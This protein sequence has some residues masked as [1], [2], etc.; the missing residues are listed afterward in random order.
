MGVPAKIEE[1][2]PGSPEAVESAVREGWKFRVDSNELFGVRIRQR[3]QEHGIHDRENPGRGSNSEHQAQHRRGR[4]AE[5]LAHY[6]N[7]ELDVLPQ[8]FHWIPPPGKGTFTACGMFLVTDDDRRL[9]RALV[10]RTALSLTCFGSTLYG[11]DGRAPRR[12]FL[13][14]RA[15]RKA[16][17]VSLAMLPTALAPCHGTSERGFQTFLPDWSRRPVLGRS[18]WPRTAIRIRRSFADVHNQLQ[19][20]RSFHV[21]EDAVHFAA[22]Q[23]IARG[24]TSGR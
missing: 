4:E 13:R 19:R 11:V 16:D 15:G 5:V 21:H 7:G 3:L 12:K 2:R 14:R 22:S 10:S 23:A 1:F 20:S 9:K 8:R 24:V 17:L 6:S 18:R